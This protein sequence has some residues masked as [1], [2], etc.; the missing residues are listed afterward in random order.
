M[1]HSIVIDGWIFYMTSEERDLLQT[2]VGM[3][4]MLDVP[5]MASSFTG[6]TASINFRIERKIGNYTSLGPVLQ[7]RVEYVQ[8]GYGKH[9]YKVHGF[10]LHGS[11][12]RDSKKVL[13][14][15]QSKIQEEV[16]RS[17]AQ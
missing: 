11:R 16:L 13:K 6:E 7:M 3:A 15:L 14:L 12:L 9:I 2:V 4:N 10:K 1:E 5:V 8:N 17:G